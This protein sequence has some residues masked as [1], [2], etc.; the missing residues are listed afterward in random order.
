MPEGE[1]TDEG[2]LARETSTVREVLTVGEMPDR[3]PVR[4]RFAFALLLQESTRATSR[5]VRTH[6][7]MACRTLGSSRTATGRGKWIKWE[8]VFL[9]N[10]SG[11]SVWGFGAQSYRPFGT[12]AEFTVVP[13]TQT[14]PLPDNVSFE[15]GTCLGVPGIIAHRAVFVAGQVSERNRPRAGSRRI[16]GS[17][18]G[19]ACAS[20][21]GACHWHG[22][23]VFR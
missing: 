8:R 1:D 6:L 11:T 15:Q 14:V 17:L 13:L 20:R 23:V 2:G 18:R 9:P 16:R 5:S 12:A 21:R 7:G 19:P 4:V 22:P 10:G 3:Y